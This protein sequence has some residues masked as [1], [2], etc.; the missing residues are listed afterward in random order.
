MTA[1]ATSSHACST[2]SLRLRHTHTAWCFIAT[3]RMTEQPVSL[4]SD[5][6]ADSEAARGD[7]CIPAAPAAVWCSRPADFTAYSERSCE[8]L[9]AKLTVKTMTVFSFRGG[10]PRIL[11]RVSKLGSREIWPQETRNI[12]L[13]YRVKVVQCLEPFSCGSRV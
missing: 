12:V 4:Q 7:V 9:Q 2:H 3:L 8:K 1:A 5:T 10:F 11:T 13:S 6:V